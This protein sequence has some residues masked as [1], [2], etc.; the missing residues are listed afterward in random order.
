MIKILIKICLVGAM[1]VRK[2]TTADRLNTVLKFNGIKSGVCEDYARDYIMKF[3]KPV[4]PWEQYA[5]L[6]GQ[7][8]KEEL[9]MKS[10]YDII[11]CDSSVVLNFVYANYMAKQFGQS[12]ATFW[13]ASGLQNL[14]KKLNKLKKD[15]YEETIRYVSSYDKTYYMPPTK[16]EVVH[17]G[18]RFGDEEAQDE[19]DRMVVGFLNSEGIPYV[20]VQGDTVD[21]KANAILRDL[22]FKYHC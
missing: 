8:E 15:L 11:I 22:G 20:T 3:G 10:D 6:L 18:V 19:I 13:E 9:L 2:S 7:K 17:D 1:S 16:K 12:I 21:E 14:D 4:F 5:I